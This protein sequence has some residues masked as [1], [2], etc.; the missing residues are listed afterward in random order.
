M[1]QIHVIRNT[2]GNL[3]FICYLQFTMYLAICGRVRDLQTIRYANLKLIF[4]CAMYHIFRALVGSRIS[5]R[6]V[7]EH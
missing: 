7:R 4:I 6:T 5:T 2:Q 1:H 3:L